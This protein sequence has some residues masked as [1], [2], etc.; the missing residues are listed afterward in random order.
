VSRSPLLDSLRRA[1]RIAALSSRGGANTPP[2]DELIDMAYSR[3][4]FLRHTAV[5]GAGVA[6]TSLAGC[7]RSDAPPEQAP[8][9]GAGGTPRI[10]I[11]GGGMAG[12]NTAYKLSKAGRPPRSTKGPI[13]R[14][15]ACSRQPTCWPT[16]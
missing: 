12:L 1:F 8:A 3:R 2:I 16:A 13:A 7:A 11:V 15:A 10:A 14:V 9:S 6:A 5:V 4:R